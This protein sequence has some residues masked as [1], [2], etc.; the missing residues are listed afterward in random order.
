[1]NK[2]GAIQI[3]V[4]WGEKGVFDYR[5]SLLRTDVVLNSEDNKTL[6]KL[7]SVRSSL[8]IN[9]DINFEKVTISAIGYEMQDNPDHNLIEVQINSDLVPRW[10]V[11]YD[12]DWY[13]YN[14]GRL[15]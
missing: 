10:Y 3:Q 7:V 9:S 5:R 13:V 2:E 14:D 1:F 12:G 4:S 15:E 11:E 6:P 8:A